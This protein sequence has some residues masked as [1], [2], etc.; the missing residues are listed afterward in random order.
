Y[1]LL[2]VSLHRVSALQEVILCDTVL[3]ASAISGLAVAWYRSSCSHFWAVASL[4]D[5]FCWKNRRQH[6]SSL[7]KGKTRG[8]NRI[9]RSWVPGSLLLTWHPQITRHTI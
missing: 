4:T 9:A 2:T 6:I 5:F 7:P 3:F 1:V 8:F